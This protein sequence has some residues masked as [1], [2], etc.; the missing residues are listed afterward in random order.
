MNQ[1][2]L[3][4][5]ITSVLLMLIGYV[6][7]SYVNAQQNICD[8]K[9]IEPQNGNEVGKK[10]IVRGTA[11]IPAGN[12]LWVVVRQIDFAPKWWPQKEAE[13]D[14]KSNEWS[15]AAYIGQKEDIGDD[16]H[17]EAIAVNA[18][19]NSRL[20]S[21]SDNAEKTKDCSPI[22]IPATTCNSSIIRV[23]KVRH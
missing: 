16:F 12:Y 6:G 23:K 17:I 8:I 11:S 4:L 10:V 20:T 9:I 3:L 18:E 5:I 2:K 1:R 22:K 7:D 21:Y 19:G 15:A 14:L 13:I